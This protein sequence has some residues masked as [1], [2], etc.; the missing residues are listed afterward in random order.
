MRSAPPA[1]RREI[2]ESLIVDFQRLRIADPASAVQ[3][4][5]DAARLAQVAQEQ[6]LFLRVLL[7]LG[8][9]YR[10]LDQ[11]R[12]AL[13]A[14][15]L[16]ERS[17]SE[18]SPTVRIDLA[19]YRSSL[20]NA[21]GRWRCTILDLSQ[22]GHSGSAEGLRQALLASAY[23]ELRAYA[24]S[25]RAA[26]KALRLAER[27]DDLW[28]ILVTLHNMIE[29]RLAAGARGEAERLFDRLEKLYSL[30]G[31]ERSRLARVQISA[32]LSIQ[33]DDAETGAR[34]LAAVRD[35]H[36]SRG[37][38]RSALHA[39][40]WQIAVACHKGTSEHLQQV[41]TTAAM[42]V[43]DVART[44]GV[45]FQALADRPLSRQDLWQ[46]LRRLTWAIGGYNREPLYRSSP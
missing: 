9:L 3:R 44:R 11:D 45:S 40:V 5:R 38:V 23:G 17:L 20:F 42:A 30:V 32:C 12:L 21:M 22:L 14:Y 37:V 29:H 25:D 35:A 10:V 27:D 19:L 4:A 39:A 13:E 15:A 41:L 26:W 16:V 8:N 33:G 18:A 36:L 24:E 6:E 46:E 2:L 1:A 31:G 34:K 7:E 43:E 28:L